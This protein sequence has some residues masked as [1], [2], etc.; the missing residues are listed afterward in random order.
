[1]RT[2]RT[3]FMFVC[4][5]CGKHQVVKIEKTWDSEISARELRDKFDEAI[6]EKEWVRMNESDVAG[7]WEYLCPTCK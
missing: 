5:N 6:K 7:F 2:N 4:A 3:D 1:M